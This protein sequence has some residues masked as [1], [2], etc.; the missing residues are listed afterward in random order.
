MVR[1]AVAVKVMVVGVETVKGGVVG[2]E[3][4]EVVG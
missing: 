3:R 2:R 4:V 1:G